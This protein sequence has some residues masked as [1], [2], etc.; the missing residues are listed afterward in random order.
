M[1][2]FP[3]VTSETVKV[4]ETVFP[5]L[6][7]ASSTISPT[8]A[9]QAVLKLCVEAAPRRR[10]LRWNPGRQTAGGVMMEPG[11]GEPLRRWRD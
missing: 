9:T 2:T 4:G 1:L 5:D 8:A 6:P 3:V 7:D 10:R 11:P